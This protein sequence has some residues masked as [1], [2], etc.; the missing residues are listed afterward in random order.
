MRLLGLDPGYGTLGF[1]IIEGDSN[2]SH[3]ISYGAITTPKTERFPERLKYIGEQI[4]KLVDQYKPDEIAIEE[5]FFQKNAKTAI[6]VA[7]ARGVILYVCECLNKPLYEYTPLQIKQS[8]T[9]YGRA[10][11]KQIQEMV[12]LILKMPEIPK[13]DDAADALAVALTHMQTNKIFGNFKI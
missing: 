4:V 8:L 13:P 9:G 5:L 7:E 2:K 10:E 12:K 6:L 3:L 11:K 1:G